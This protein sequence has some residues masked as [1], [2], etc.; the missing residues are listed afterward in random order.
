MT[1]PTFPI[2]T[3]TSQLLEQTGPYAGREIS[4]IQLADNLREAQLLAAPQ[5]LDWLTSQ[6]CSDVFRVSSGP[7]RG[8]KGEPLAFEIQRAGNLDCLPV[9]P[10]PRT[11]PISARAALRGVDNKTF[12]PG[13]S[14]SLLACWQLSEAN[15]KSPD[16]PR[17]GGRWFNFV[18]L[19]P[20]QPAPTLITNPNSITHWDQPRLLTIEEAK[21]L[22]SFPDNFELVGTYGQQ[23]KQIGNSVPPLLTKAIAEDLLKVLPR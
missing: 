1:A 18:R 19:D 17:L 3:L 13:L 16:D 15:G 14:P 23:W 2:Q 21:R 4:S 6:S 20:D 10:K 8:I 5:I 9:L 12:H 7:V 11:A 22:Q